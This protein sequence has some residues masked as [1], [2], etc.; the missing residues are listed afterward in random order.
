VY[1]I[2][3]FFGSTLSR[4]HEVTRLS[5]A[6]NIIQAQADKKFVASG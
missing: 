6:K 4:P 5:C 1:V 2:A 3:I